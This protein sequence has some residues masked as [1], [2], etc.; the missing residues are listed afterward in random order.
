MISIFIFGSLF[1][2]YLNNIQSSQIMN[3][4]T[5][6]YEIDKEKLHIFIENKEKEKQVFSFPLKDFQ[7]GR[8]KKISNLRFDIREIPDEYPAFIKFQ[9]GFMTRS[10]KALELNFKN[11][12]VYL[13]P[14]QINE[15]FLKIHEELKILFKKEM[16]KSKFDKNNNLN[17][18]EI[19]PSNK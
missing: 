9:H 8:I 11:S 15:F 16:I 14:S 10:G 1:F 18:F 4:S 2:K 13:T 3:I 12:R 17:Y 7:N 6:T 19:I 5:L